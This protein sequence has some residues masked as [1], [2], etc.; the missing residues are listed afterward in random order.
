MSKTPK[1]SSGIAA[2]VVTGAS[3]VG[4]NVGSGFATGVEPLQFFSAWGWTGALVSLGTACL[5]VMLVFTLVYLSGFDRHYSDENQVYRHFFGTRLYKVFIFYIYATM[6]LAT[7]TMLSGAGATIQQH[8]GLPT[9]AGTILMGALCIAASLLGLGRLRHLLSYLCVVLVVF[10]IALAVYTAATTDLSPAAGAAGAAAYA[11]SGQILR[12][13]PFALKSPVISGIASGGLLISSGFAWAAATGTL[14][15]NRKE[16]AASGLFSGLFYY[17]LTAAATYLIC[18]N[19]DI[20]A[21]KEVPLL[22]IIQHGLEI[23]TPVYSAIILIAIFAT[24]TGRLFLI[25]EQFGKG[26]R[27][28]GLTIVISLTILASAAA[29]FL[30]FGELSN[31]LFL[32]CGVGGTII[33]II[34]LVRFFADVSAK[35]RKA[36]R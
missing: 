14:C 30:P 22:A 11:E 9:F 24:I 5:I 3:F 12:V 32:V 2:A 26:N 35:R 17:A 7:L 15:T 10:V 34:I 31:V 25:G 18:V 28:K 23:L 1:H 20:V 36:A 4:F 13:E 27:K 19:M 21:G 29:S 6:T 33:G 16:A 8:I